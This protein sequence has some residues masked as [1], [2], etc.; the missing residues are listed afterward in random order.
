MQK[1]T[2]NAIAIILA[3][4][5]MVACFTGCASTSSSTSTTGSTGASSTGSPTDAATT[6]TKTEGTAPASSGS[7]YPTKD[8][9]AICQWG[10]GGGTDNVVRPICSV[11][12]SLTD[13]NII[14]QNMS[15]GTGVIGLQYVHDQAPDGYTLLLGAENP[16]IYKAMN[17]S[18]LSYDNF[19]PIC[20]CAY[21]ESVFIVPANSP[22]KTMT[23]V[24]KAALANPNGLN[25]GHAG[26]GSSSW[27]ACA[28]TTVVTG[29]K[30]TQVPYDSDASV[31]AAIMGG[32]CDIST[33]KAKQAEDGVRSGSIRVLAALTTE[34]NAIFPDVPPITDEYPDFANYLPYVAYYGVFVREGTPDDVVDYLVKLFQEAY[35]SD[36]YQAA[37]KGLGVTPLGLYGDE[38][39][40]WIAN[41]QRNVATGLYRAG[42]ID[43]SPEE[44]GI[45]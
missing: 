41:W 36:D 21:D 44:L 17:L 15:G 42:E 37:L 10:A 26:D 23:D 1:S 32:E 31:L 34:Q 27:V 16:G 12:Q 22:Y 6:E 13:V 9:S 29:A 19:I 25:F 38:A 11:A 35:N 7:D 40:E 14:V 43:K 4:L 8:I 39:A 2:K 18:Q 28:Y 45:S 5:F 24:V 30:F 3:L 20:L 33:I